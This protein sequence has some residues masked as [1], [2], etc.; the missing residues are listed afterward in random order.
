MPSAEL[1]PSTSSGS[2]CS[3]PPFT[4]SAN[5]PVS[6]AY[7]SSSTGPSLRRACSALRRPICQASD[8][9]SSPARHRMRIGSARGGQ[10]QREQCTAVDA[11][12]RRGE[13]PVGRA[14][15]QGKGADECKG[16]FLHGT[17][18]IIGGY[19][20]EARGRFSP[21]TEAFDIAVWKWGPMRE[22]MLE[23]AAMSQ[24]LRRRGR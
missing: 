11:Y 15:G 23:S 4:T 6:L 20:M 19:I 13:E 1:A 7:S 21:S 3:H 2:T 5:L 17:F 10:A 12:V 16:I 14:R 9:S 8:G 18:H 22:R 24:D